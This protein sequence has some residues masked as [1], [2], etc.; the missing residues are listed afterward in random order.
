MSR[1]A[2][3][4]SAMKLIYQMYINSENTEELLNGF[5]ENEEHESSVEDRVF[6]GNC[7]NGV[8]EK[9]V[10]IDANIEKYLKGWKLNRI[11]KVDLAIMRLAVYEMMYGNDVPDVVAVNE[12][13][14]LAKT[15]GGDNS[16]S[17]INGILGNLI[18]ELKENDQNI[19]D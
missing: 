1:K 7:V 10:E 11:S 4:E 8:K 6:I 17:F 3:R 14:E 12:A 15:F 19:R 13:V 9:E 2:A 16:P 5:Y 18:K